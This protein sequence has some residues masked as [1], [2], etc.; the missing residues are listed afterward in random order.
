MSQYFE[1]IFDQREKRKG[2]Y[3]STVKGYDYR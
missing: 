1:Y 2:H 3:V